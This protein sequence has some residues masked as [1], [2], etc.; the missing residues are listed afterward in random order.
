MLSIKNLHASIGDKEIL[1]G[2][3]LE[4]K[5]GEIHA[6]MGP[7][8]AGKSTL[9]S[10]IAGNENYE[11]TGGE[12]SLDGEDLAELAPE[13][14]AHK[15]VFLS[16]QYPVEIPGVSVTNFMRTAINET[17]KANGQDEMPA[18]EMLKL[19]REKSELLEIDRKF[20]SRSLNEGFSGGEKKRNEIFQ[21]A[22]LEP[23]LA[24]L[25]ETDSGLDIDALRI[26]ANG[27]NKLKSDKNAIVVITHY[28]RLLDYIVPDFVHVLYNGKIVKS[29]GKELAHELEE[30][31]YD[32]IKQ[33]Q[34]A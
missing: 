28:Q 21:M 29:G 32:W 11:V 8:G 31:G 4:V 16:F 27:V 22:M 34:E 15:G 14:R 23:K 30:K 24:I 25:D 19:I 5:A 12:I 6:I 9:A 17:R 3:N 10:I 26:V 2:I 13:E 20:L 7:N 1:K 33:E 18:N